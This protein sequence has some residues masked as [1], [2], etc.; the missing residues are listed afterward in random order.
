MAYLDVMMAFPTLKAF[1]YLQ[2]RNVFPS[3]LFLPQNMQFVTGPFRVFRNSA[4]GKSTL[5]IEVRDL[6][7]DMR[8]QIIIILFGVIDLEYGM[9]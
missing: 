5:Q 2:F 1:I 8:W 6:Y 9:I 4:S 7:L 3:L